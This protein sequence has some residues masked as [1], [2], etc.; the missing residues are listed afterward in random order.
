MAKLSDIRSRDRRNASIALAV[1]LTGGAIFMGACILN[2]Y[3]SSTRR[4]PDGSRGRTVERL[5]RGHP[6]F[7]TPAESILDSSY[8]AIGSWCLIMT[9]GILHE[10][11][12]RRLQPEKK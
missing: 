11:W 4:A 5:H 8:L 10:Y 3:W 9:G 7:V 1:V 2:V 6:Y 12:M